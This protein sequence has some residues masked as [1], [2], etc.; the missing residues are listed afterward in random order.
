MATILLNGEKRLLPGSPTIGA[1]ITDLG[2]DARGGIA[3]EVNEEIVPKSE[4][5]S[6]SLKDGDRVE[7]VTM[8]AGG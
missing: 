8:M 2:L 3:V 4:H 7:I 6:F 5:A 1:L